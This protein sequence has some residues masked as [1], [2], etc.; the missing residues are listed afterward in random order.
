MN[1]G[2]LTVLELDAQ[3]DRIGHY[4]TQELCEQLSNGKESAGRALSLM[5]MRRSLC[6][7]SRPTIEAVKREVVDEPQKEQK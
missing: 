5:E 6:L 1:L 4:Y 2:D 3:L 7:N